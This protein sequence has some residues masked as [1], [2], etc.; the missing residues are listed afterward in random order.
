MLRSWKLRIL[1]CAEITFWEE[2]RILQFIIRLY[3]FLKLGITILCSKNNCL[4]A[5]S[6]AFLMPV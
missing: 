6:S 3:N 1:L 4:S 2:I 5:I